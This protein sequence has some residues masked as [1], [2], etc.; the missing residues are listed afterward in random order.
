VPEKNPTFLTFRNF[1]TSSG[2]HSIVYTA[3]LA[4]MEQSSFSVW[5]LP[6][7]QRAT[8]HVAHL[9]HNRRLGGGG[10]GWWWWW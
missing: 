6:V 8:C 5:T 7:F 9:L 10:G 4:N 2:S 3:S 1:K